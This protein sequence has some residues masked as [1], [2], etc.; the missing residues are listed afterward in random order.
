MQKG[1]RYPRCKYCKRAI[2]LGGNG[3]EWMT[4]HP[5][6]DL[7]IPSYR[8]SFNCIRLRHDAGAD[9]STLEGFPHVLETE[10]ERYL[11]KDE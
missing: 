8:W 2:M 4:V 6:P 10:F 3:S 11:K 7:D 9:A 5:A 1:F